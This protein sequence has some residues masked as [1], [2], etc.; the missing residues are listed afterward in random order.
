MRRWHS[1]RG[2]GSLETLELSPPLSPASHGDVDLVHGRLHIDC[3]ATWGA[4]VEQAAD[5]L[6]LTNLPGHILPAAP[7]G[8]ER[9]P[10]AA[11]PGAP[12]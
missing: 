5:S 12:L 4:S 10:V 6:D 9:R 8:P 1:G 2:L 11:S 3:P 7:L